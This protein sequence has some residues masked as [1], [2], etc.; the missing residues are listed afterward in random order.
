M[1][2]TDKSTLHL[3]PYFQP[4]GL[5]QP[6]DPFM[7]TQRNLWYLVT[8]DPFWDDEPQPDFPT[9]PLLYSSITPTPLIRSERD[10]KTMLCT[11][12]YSTRR[13]PDRCLFYDRSRTKNGFQSIENRVGAIFNEL[14]FNFSNNLTDEFIRIS[15]KRSLKMIN[16]SETNLSDANDWFSNKDVLFLREFFIFYWQ[17]NIFCILLLTLSFIA[18]YDGGGF[19]HWVRHL[20]CENP[21]FSPTE[22]IR[23]S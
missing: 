10:F 23:P 12:S 16:V 7:A 5:H 13:H 4:G 22:N 18:S 19:F 11:T 6:L 2:K 1:V 14:D 17:K 15:L 21:S 3:P 8:L 20:I 9:F